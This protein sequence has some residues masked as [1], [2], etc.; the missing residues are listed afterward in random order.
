[1]G[2]GQLCCPG[3]G[4]GP[5]RAEGALKAEMLQILRCQRLCRRRHRANLPSTKECLQ[6]SQSACRGMPRQMHVA[7][8]GKPKLAALR[9]FVQHGSFSWLHTNRLNVAMS[10]G[11]S[12]CYSHGNCAFAR[13]ELVL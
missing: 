8:C 12:R 1:M 2:L 9:L 4:T 5:A 6:A 7:T 3:T 10:V 11:I 13:V